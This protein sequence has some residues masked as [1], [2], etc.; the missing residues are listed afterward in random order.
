MY[1]KGGILTMGEIT[2]SQHMRFDAKDTEDIKYYLRSIAELTGLHFDGV[3]TRFN[4]LVIPCSNKNEKMSKDQFNKIV[5]EVVRQK[6]RGRID[7]YGDMVG[8]QRISIS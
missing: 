7:F 8:G 3:E 1:G 5:S 2:E 4:I 6:S